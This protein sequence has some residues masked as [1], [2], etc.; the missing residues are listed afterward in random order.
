MRALKTVENV[1]KSS[2]TFGLQKYPKV[3]FF[4]FCFLIIAMELACVMTVLPFYIEISMQLNLKLVFVTNF[5][6]LLGN[7][8][9]PHSPFKRKL[10]MPAQIVSTT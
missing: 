8:D 1:A 10:G 7:S 4:T 9:K 5:L 3:M 6:G 2:F